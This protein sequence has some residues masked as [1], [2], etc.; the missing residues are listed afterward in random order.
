M[1]P[2]LLRLLRL[3]AAF[4]TRQHALHS[5]GPRLF[6]FLLRDLIGNLDNASCEGRHRNTTMMQSNTTSFGAAVTARA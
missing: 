6:L 5:G 1:L 4:L 3:L 2:M